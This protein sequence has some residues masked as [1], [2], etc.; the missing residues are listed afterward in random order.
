MGGGNIVPLSLKAFFGNIRATMI[1]LLLVTR[2]L[3]LFWQ[4]GGEKI[5]KIRELQSS[6]LGSLAG[7]SSNP[8]NPFPHTYMAKVVEDAF[9]S[10]FA[11]YDRPSVP[12]N[13]K[14]KCS[15]LLIVKYYTEG[16]I[17]KLA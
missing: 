11:N 8:F 6:T 4:K 2:S 9:K 7:L 12:A 3:Q 5:E 10:S 13:I 17:Y 14:S 1:G 16:C 15:K